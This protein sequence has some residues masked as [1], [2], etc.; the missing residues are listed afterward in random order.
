M[1][2]KLAKTLLTAAVVFA[3]P[4]VVIGTAVIVIYNNSQPTPN[5]FATEINKFAEQLRANQ[6]PTQPVPGQPAA[7]SLRPTPGLASDGL[8][9][10][11]KTRKARS[12]ARTAK[13]DGRVSKGPRSIATATRS[14]RRISNRYEPSASRHIISTPVGIASSLKSKCG[15]C[16]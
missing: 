9:P 2:T 16:N 11:T 14:T 12:S 7:G 13:A 4:A 1:N 5:E 6:S 10:S 15:W 3:V 8:V